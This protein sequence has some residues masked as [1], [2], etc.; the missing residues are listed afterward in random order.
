S[1]L[2][3]GAVYSRANGHETAI[4]FEE[5]L[6]VLSRFPLSAPDLRQLASR[7]NPFVRRLA[8]SALLD[9]PY[10]KLRAISVHLGLL[11]RQNA[12][13]LRRLQDWVAEAPAGC[14]ALI[15]GDFN[16]REGSARMVR[17][18]A[19]WLDPFRQLHPAATA[20]TH[21]LRWPWGARLRARRLDYIF[22][23]ANQS[24]WGVLEAR[25]VDA[26]GGPHSDHR[27]VLLRLTPRPPAGD[28]R[29]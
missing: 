8:L 1:R 3:M 7:A 24:S 6:A 11:P 28:C 5:G 15:G 17:A 16:S 12:A 4:G 22:L 20:V 26:P 21:E 9:T 18:R 2:G 10:G 29:A 25:H 23:R 13:Q 27:A 19:A 14:P